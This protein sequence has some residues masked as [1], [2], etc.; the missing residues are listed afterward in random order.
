MNRERQISIKGIDPLQLLGAGD[1]NLRLIEAS[2]PVK[3]VARGDV[4]RFSGE[5][6]ELDRLER[7]WMEALFLLNKNGRL[8]IAD[9]RSAILRVRNESPEP[10]GSAPAAA[11]ENFV[12]FGKKGVIRPKTPGQERY[13]RAALTNEIVFAVGPAGTGKTYLAVAIAVEKLRAKEVSRII[14]TRPAIEAGENLGYLPGDLMEKVDPYLRPLTDAL[15]DML[16]ND[17]L[18][19]YLERKV[20]EI[21]PLAYMRGR[22]LNDAFVILDEAQNTTPMQMKMFLT[23]LGIGSRGIV[24]GDDTQT[25][26]PDR[27]LSGLVQ[28][29]SILKGIEGIDFVYLDKRDVVRHRLVKDILQAYESAS[30]RIPGGSSGLDQGVGSAN[31][32]DMPRGM[33]PHMDH[34]FPADRRSS[35]VS[36]PGPG[37]N[38]SGTWKAD[39][40]ELQSFNGGATTAPAGPR[41][42]PGSAAARPS[43]ETPGEPSGGDRPV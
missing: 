5:D 21:V 16:P 39:G 3:I 28:I 24:T 35:A 40:G 11:A 19:K 20:I 10:A 8:D 13:C 43:P 34:P 36:Q 4:I 42:E 22:T 2:F 17:Q 37:R 32:G 9:V 38:T 31:N 7:F 27:S 29:Q 23:R 12:F 6:P 1:E 26:L 15:F 25:D 41:D 33:R 14:L 18:Q 30:G